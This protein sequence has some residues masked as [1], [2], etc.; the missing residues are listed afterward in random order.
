MDDKFED[1]Q[2]KTIAQI[3]AR[4]TRLNQYDDRA[5]A[6]LYRS[7][8]AETACAGWLDSTTERVIDC[9]ITWALTTPADL[10]MTEEH[11]SWKALLY[12]TLF[13]KFNI[14]QAALDA[15]ME[16]Q[17]SNPDKFDILID[18]TPYLRT[19]IGAPTTLLEYKP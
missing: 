13:Q 1:Y 16:E 6:S 14:T 9:F 8:S 11:E 5:I 4:N 15:A 12:Q 19:A 3:R 7:Y 18:P 10:F 17:G 2:I